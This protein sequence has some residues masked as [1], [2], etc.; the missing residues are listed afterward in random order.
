MQRTHDTSTKEERKQRKRAAK[1]AELMEVIPPRDLSRA[2]QVYGSCQNLRQLQRQYG[3]KQS[4]DTIFEELRDMYDRIFA[5]SAI[6]D[7]DEE[8]AYIPA[9]HGEYSGLTGVLSDGTAVLDFSMHPPVS[10]LV[11]LNPNWA[12]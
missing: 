1:L 12:D 10:S 3:L 6:T 5:E 9:L 11:R 4:N 8:E 2:F 7:E